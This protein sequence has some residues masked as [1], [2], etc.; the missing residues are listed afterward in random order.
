MAVYDATEPFTGAGPE[1]AAAF[2]RAVDEQGVTEEERVFIRGLPRHR[3]RGVSAVMR[4]HDGKAR[5][6]VL[7]RIRDEM[8]AVRLR[9]A[10]GM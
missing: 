3:R 7:A 5:A 9:S 8:K 2:A 4:Q 1:L 10:R 6:A